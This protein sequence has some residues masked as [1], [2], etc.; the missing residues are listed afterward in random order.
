M[1]YKFF[2]VYFNIVSELNELK[3]PIEVYKQFIDSI[4]NTRISGSNFNKYWEN[5]SPHNPRIEIR[6]NLTQLSNM[7]T[8]VQKIGDSLVQ[9]HIIRSCDSRLRD[10]PEPNFVT[11]AH[12]T[13]TLCA[14]T[15]KERLDTHPHTYETLVANPDDFMWKFVVAILRQAGFRPNI[16]WGIL[17]TPIPADINELASD[18]SDILRQSIESNVPLADFIE[19]FVHCFFN[20]TLSNERTLLSYLQ[21]SN[22][23][24]SLANSWQTT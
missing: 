7:E 23:W 12:E 9:S 2:I 19:R 24:H 22:I 17:R 4:G 3:R 18:C 5:T 1:P 6:M 10:W 21:V 11:K 16:I 15:F 20:C 8:S 13:A 14:V